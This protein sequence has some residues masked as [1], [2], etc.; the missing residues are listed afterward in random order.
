[1]NQP[2]ANQREVFHGPLCRNQCDRWSG[3]ESITAKLLKLNSAYRE[4]SNNLCKVK[5][6]ALE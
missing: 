4:Y 3:T 6:V 1:M 5:N 2:F